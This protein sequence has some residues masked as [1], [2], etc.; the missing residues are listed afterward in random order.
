VS[1]E[2]EPEVLEAAVEADATE[3]AEEA[4]PGLSAAALLSQPDLESWGEIPED[5]EPIQLTGIQM[6]EIR[7]AIEEVALSEAEIHEA[8]RDAEGS[9]GTFRFEVEPMDATGS[10][11]EL[12]ESLVDG[13]RP[14]NEP[15]ETLR[16]VGWYSGASGYEQ[17]R[18]QAQRMGRPMVVYFHTDWCPY[19]RAF[20]TSYL[21]D[22]LVRRFLSN[23]VRI[24]VNP[25]DGDIEMALA[26]RYGVAGYPSFFI[27]PHGLA[28]EDARRV[29][30][31]RNNKEIPVE[32]F[33]AECEDATELR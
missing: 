8:G 6:K 13:P 9:E 32:Q 29:H 24:H 11:S 16:F 2:P 28:V 30:P 23:V 27:L 1:P 19:C 26:Q 33:V 7:D 15:E 17:G 21:T 22:P 18:R 4:P 14:Q 20:D 10:E 31:F 3:L 25:E 12:V 5:R